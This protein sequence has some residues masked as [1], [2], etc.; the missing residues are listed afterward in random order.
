MNKATIFIVACAL[1]LAGAGCS[2]ITDFPDDLLDK[3]TYSLSANIPEELTVSLAQAP[4]AVL[5]LDLT[6]PLPGSEDDAEEMSA[7]LGDTLSVT[8]RRSDQLTADLTQ[9]TLIA[10]DEKPAEAGEYKIVLNDER[11]QI[12]IVFFNRIEDMS[13][14][15]ENEYEA[16]I[17]VKENDYFQS[18]NFTRN[19]AVTAD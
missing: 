15:A 19:V 13:L 2:L 6:E 9:G 3:G 16:R 10:A 8:V 12:S 11:D 14:H 5:A 7:L 18:E 17:E 4:V 1:A